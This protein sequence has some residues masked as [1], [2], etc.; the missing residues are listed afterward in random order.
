MSRGLAAARYSWRKLSA[1]KWGDAWLE[2]L[3]YLGPQRAMVIEISGARAARVE[4]H[5]L[6]KAEGEALVKLFGGR[7]TEA[8]WLT[9]IDPP[10]RPPIRVRGRLLIFSTPREME[11]H[12]ASGSR[13]PALLIPAGMAFG[14]GG[15]ATTA[16]C[17][18]LLVDASRAQ[19]AGAWDLLDLGTGS[20]ILAL[21]GR[22]L[23]ARSVE[24]GDFDP[25]A[26]RTAKQNVRTNATTRVRIRRLE[27]PP[28]G[29][30]SPVADHLRQSLQRPAPRDCSQVCACRGSRRNA[31]LFRHPPRAGGR[32]PHRLRPHR[33]RHRESRPQREMGQRRGAVASGETVTPTTETDYELSMRESGAP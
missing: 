18:R 24:A 26:V 20:G 7:L 16:T 13:T 28:M 30:R 3:S 33:L 19:L 4:A 32:S 12:H 23:G 22:A 1:A 27:R 8:K 2:R 9:A 6:T 25:H 17:L 21:A 5:G 11:E 31:H 10:Q 29:A 14:T 15:H